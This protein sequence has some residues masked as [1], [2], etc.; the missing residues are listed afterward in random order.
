[1]YN[2]SSSKTNGIIIMIVDLFFVIAIAIINAI[3]ANK[4]ACKIWNPT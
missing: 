1:M 4:T 3:T 2:D